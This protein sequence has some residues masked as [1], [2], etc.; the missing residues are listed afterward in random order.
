MV[1]DHALVWVTNVAGVEH[2][3]IVLVRSTLTRA[4]LPLFM[5]V[6]G[7]LLARRCDVSSRRLLQVLGAA[8]VVTLVNAVP[9]GVGFVRPDVLVVFSIVLG[10]LVLPHRLGLA[11]PN[12]LWWVG[13][14]AVQLTVWPDPMAGY[15]PGLLLLYLG[16]GALAGPGVLAAAGERLPAFLAPLGRRPLT[17]YVGHMVLL[18]A[19]ALV[20]R[21]T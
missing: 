3:A 9:G 11:T 5:F 18:A 4:A 12:P 20:W 8:T 17:I 6:A 10:L 21:T 2:V 7:S 19:A 16:A 13:I 15:D 14:G 1:I